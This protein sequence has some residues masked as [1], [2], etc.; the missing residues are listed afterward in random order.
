[1]LHICC[2]S[3]V[4][5]HELSVNLNYVCLQEIFIAKNIFC[6]NLKTDMFMHMQ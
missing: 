6:S 3:E 1:M 2:N 4:R 5:L